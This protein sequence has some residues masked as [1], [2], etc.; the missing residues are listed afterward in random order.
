MRAA[1]AS[2]PAI[3]VPGDGKPGSLP[4]FV[5]AVNPST[6]RSWKE[7]KLAGVSMPYEAACETLHDLNHLS[8]AIA[9]TFA[10]VE[11]G[12]GDAG[13]PEPEPIITETST[14]R[15]MSTSR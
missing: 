1:M 4:R 7:S 5:P 6:V 15:P 2:A 13:K 14:V 10:A 8:D 3:V 11:R 12:L 9:G